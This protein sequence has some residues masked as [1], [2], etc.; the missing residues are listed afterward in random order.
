MPLH[1]LAREISSWVGS[2]VKLSAIEESSD[3]SKIG[4]Y[5][6]IVEDNGIGISFESQPRVFDVFFKENNTSGL[7]VGLSV[8][9]DLIEK[10]GGRIILVSRPDVGTR[11]SILFPLAAY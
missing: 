10:M 6:F 9:K 3:N 7:G 4:N 8:A 1:S 11:V 2:I 5:T